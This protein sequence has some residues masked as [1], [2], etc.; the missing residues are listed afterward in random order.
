MTTNTY[1]FTR[2]L[3]I[4]REYDVV[5]AGG[6][7]AGCAAAIAA[8]RSGASVLLIE[9]SGALGGMGTSG[10][11]SNWGSLSDGVRI[12]TKGIFWEILSLTQS[13]GYLPPQTDIHAPRFVERRNAGSGFNPE[14]VKLILDELCR[15][16]GVTTRFCTRVIDADVTNRRIN[17]V[18]INNVEGCTYVP[19]A[20]FVD[21]TGDAALADAAGADCREAGRDT[22]KIMPPTLC[23]VAAD[24]DW[25]QFDYKMQQQAI[26]R[27]MEENFLSQ[28]DRHVPGLFRSGDTTGTLN[29]GHLF[30]MNAL[31]SESLSWGYVQGRRFAEEYI[32]CFRRYLKGCENIKLIATAALMGVRESRRIVGEYELNYGDFKAH[33]HFPDQIG[34]YNKSVDIHVYDVSPDEY[35]R[36]VGEFWDADILKDGQ[37]YG[38]PYRILVPKGFVNLWAAGRCVSSDIKVN[39]SLRDQPGAYIMGQAAGTAAAQSVQT[40]K[41]AP[42]LDVAHLQET[43][44]KNGAYLGDAVSSQS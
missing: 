4:T 41:A 31:D 9:G 42:E 7:P 17:G 37:S 32:E 38:L 39:G 14:G 11:V 27:G 33:R 10:L 44:Q 23:A 34:V 30:G 18:I 12:L 22:E 40:N 24:I 26:A 36:H 6:G 2:K 25:S 16:A 29:A 19:G 21:A 13:R 8:A 20:A 5:V 15:E 35:R 3:K 43:L 1:T 28:K